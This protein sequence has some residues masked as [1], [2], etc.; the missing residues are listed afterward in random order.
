MLD[1]LV[2]TVDRAHDELVCGNLDLWGEELDKSWQIKKKFAGGISNP[3]IDKMY[4][5]ARDAGALGGKILGAGGGGFLLL[6][7]KKDR[8]TDVKTV[9]KEFRQVPFALEPQGSRIIFSD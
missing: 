9:L 2:A 3:V 4:T 5:A 7:T 6:Y 8:Q 1:S